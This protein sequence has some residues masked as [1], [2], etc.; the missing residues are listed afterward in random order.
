MPGR[1]TVTALT[2]ITK[3]GK[4]QVRVRACALAIN[5][6]FLNSTPLTCHSATEVMLI[7][8]PNAAAKPPLSAL[9]LEMRV[10]VCERERYDEFRD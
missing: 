3:D 9:R 2:P 5:P 10:C 4:D 1:F 8:Q 7:R 6:T